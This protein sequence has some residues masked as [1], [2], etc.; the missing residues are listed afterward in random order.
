MARREELSDEQWKVIAPLLPKGRLKPG[1]RGRPRQDDRSIFNGILWILR[2]GARW[3]DLPERFPSYQTCH[4]RFQQWVRSGVIRH[5]LEA[6][7]R[8][9]HE[10]GGFDLSECYIDATFMIAKK[11]ASG[12]EK[13][14][15][16]RV[17]SSWQWQT[18]LVF[19]SPFTLHLLRRMKSP[20]YTI[21]SKNG[22]S[23]RD[24]GF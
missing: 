12:S 1:G 16:A 11:G 18:A 4:R 22:F 8:D 23:D 15:G 7:A 20:W 19:L 10:R 3:Q 21:L 14:S 17:Q 2:S 9:L 6:L 13:P 5:L 24:L